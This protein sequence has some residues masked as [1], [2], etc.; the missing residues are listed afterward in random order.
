MVNIRDK[1]DFNGG[2][3]KDVK[4]DDMTVIPRL[5]ELAAENPGFYDQLLS[6]KDAASFLDYPIETLAYWRGNGQ[7]PP[8]LRYGKRVRYRRRDL[9][10][11]IEAHTVRPGEGAGNGQQ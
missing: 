7:G 8:F 11:W 9:I 4:G 6:T 3:P 10:A 5:E 2:A 1:E